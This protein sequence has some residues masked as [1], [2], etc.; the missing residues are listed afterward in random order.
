MILSQ[1]ANQI[2]KLAQDKIYF[3]IWIA[4]AICAQIGGGKTGTY[5]PATFG[6]RVQLGVG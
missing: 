1:A 2:I 3:C 5:Q 6:N 4:H